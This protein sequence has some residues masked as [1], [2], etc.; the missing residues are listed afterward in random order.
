MAADGRHFVVVDGFSF[1]LLLLVS[2][3]WVDHCHWY[4]G[5]SVDVGTSNALV[6]AL[7]NLY[8]KQMYCCVRA[9]FSIDVLGSI[10]DALVLALMSS[11]GD[12][13]TM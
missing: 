8:Q 4:I 2:A 11:V 7:T 12:C 9:D 5:E 1:W 13:V 6:L 10:V 3:V